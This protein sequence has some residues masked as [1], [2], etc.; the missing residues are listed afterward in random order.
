MAARRQ[1]ATKADAPAPAHPVEVAAPAHGVDNT[2]S[3]LLQHVIGIT[4]DISAL[5][6]KID[7]LTDEVKE[8]RKELSAIR[9]EWTKIKGV[10][11]G[12]AAVAVLAGGLVWWLVGPKVQAVLVDP[13]PIP[14]QT[15]PAAPIKK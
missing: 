2:H 3:F 11:G 12:A 6:T 10:V 4:R 13:P 14:A 9:S 8:Q 7:T 1:S 15:A 5:A